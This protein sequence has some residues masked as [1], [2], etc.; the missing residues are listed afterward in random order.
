[1]SPSLGEPQTV[2]TAAPLSGDM[3]VLVVEDSL[4]MRQ[5]LEWILGKDYTVQSA[6]DGLVGME[7]YGSF[8]PEVVL[9]DINMPKA[10]GYQVIEHIRQER[11]D[12]DTFIIMLTAEESQDS[13]L[14]ALN[15]GANDFLSKPFDRT[16][17]LARIRVAERQ[18]RLTRQL[19][20]H[21]EKVQKELE[22]VALLQSKLLPHESPYFRGVRVQSL[23]RPS[24]QAS[25]DYFDFFP[26]NGNGIRVVMADVSGHGARAA[27]LMAIVR[28]LFRTTETLYLPLD[29]TM[30]LVNNHLTQ[31]IGQETDFVTVFAADLNFE[32]GSLRYLNCGHAPGMLRLPDGSVRELPA[33]TSILGF[34]ELEFQEEE[35]AFPLGSQL[36]LFT[37]GFY[38][39]EPEPG[40]ILDLDR[41]W[42]LA[43]TA[44]N[45]GG[46]FLEDLMS[47]LSA[48]STTIPR[49]KDDLTA[50]W[51][52]TEQ[53][54][55]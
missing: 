20:S 42:N 33:Q 46:D 13:K 10:D 39:W 55:V 18:V 23:Y 24:G 45:K 19:R 3:K 30:A 11:G 37:D 40:S 51:I 8:A 34:F 27:F 7:R 5:T 4:S 26:I 9:L 28:T 54:S 48:L 35:V 14:K 36:F 2:R 38:E 32:Q 52:K 17:L 6:P 53:D 29:R 43:Q 44:M 47:E 25:G 12:Q 50:L 22:L 49:F 16:E 1:M 41:F 31:I 15:L 21:M